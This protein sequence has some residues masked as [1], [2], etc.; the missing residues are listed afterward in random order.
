[1]LIFSGADL[2]DA[3]IIDANLTN[4]YLADADLTNAI[5]PAPI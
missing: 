3:Y 1:M 4:A 5:S 2:S